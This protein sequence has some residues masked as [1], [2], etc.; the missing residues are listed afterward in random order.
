MCLILVAWRAHPRYPLVIAANR[1]EFFSRPTAGASESSAEQSIEPGTWVPRPVPPPTYTLKA[2]APERPE[3][4]PAEVT[5]TPAGAG[6][7][8]GS[9][10]EAAGAAEAGERRHTAAG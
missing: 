4:M 2:K 10:A 7:S 8:A 5:P 1:D 6:E 3:V 9:A